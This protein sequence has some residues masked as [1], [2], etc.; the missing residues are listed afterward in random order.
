MKTD[1]ESS[2]FDNYSKSRVQCMVIPI[3]T[4]FTV[5]ALFVNGVCSSYG[6]SGVPFYVPQCMR[7]QLAI[8]RMTC[9]IS[10]LQ[11][12]YISEQ[13]RIRTGG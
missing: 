4:D 9:H 8:Y 6:I 2:G 3:T 5:T 13:E 10:S 7:K 1:R 11:L 12:G